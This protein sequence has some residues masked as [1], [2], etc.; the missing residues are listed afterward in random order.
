[1]VIKYAK[2]SEFYCLLPFLLK[3]NKNLKKKKKTPAD[4][5]VGHAGK[6]ICC[7]NPE[8]SYQSVS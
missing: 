2:K 7:H 8:R 6:I 1:V 3:G 5:W 4:K